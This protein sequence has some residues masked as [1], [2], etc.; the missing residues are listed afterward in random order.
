M[1]DCAWQVGVQGTRTV[2]E[3]G[4]SEAVA[5]VVLQVFR[6]N[7]ICGRCK[8][9]RSWLTVELWWLCQRKDVRGYDPPEVAAS[10]QTSVLGAVEI[11]GSPGP[12]PSGLPPPTPHPPA[13]HRLRHPAPSRQVPPRPALQTQGPHGRGDERASKPAAQGPRGRLGL[14]RCPPPLP[15][16]G[17]SGRPAGAA[18]REDGAPLPGQCAL[19][20]GPPLRRPGN[21]ARRCGLETEG[22]GRRR[23]TP[24]R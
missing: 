19:H 2:T 11:P 22:G 8:N 20:R 24:G 12:A 4:A 14:P 6:I 18:S 15:P 16:L 21:P 5:I 17:R 23:R 9:Q 7:R 13:A 3:R 1:A 10:V